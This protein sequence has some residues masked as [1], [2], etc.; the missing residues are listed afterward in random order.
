MHVDFWEQSVAPIVAKRYE[1]PLY[2]IKDIPYAFKRA[3]IVGDIVYYGEAT[4][5]ELLDKIRKALKNPRL[6]FV[7]DEHESRLPEDVAHLRGLITP[8]LLKQALSHYQ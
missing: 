2:A 5:T 6:R 7:Y 8:S 1:L 3:R 4:S